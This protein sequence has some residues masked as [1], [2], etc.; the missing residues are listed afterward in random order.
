MA[1]NKVIYGNNTLIDISDTT[2][3]ESD[4]SSGAVFYKNNGVR[5]VGTAS[6][7]GFP[8]FTLTGTITPT[9]SGG[10]IES[11][12]LKYALTSDRTIGMI[13]GGALVRGAGAGVLIT[14]SLGVQ[15]S[16][17]PSSDV[18]IKGLMNSSVVTADNSSNW[19]VGIDTSGNVTLNYQCSTNRAF[20]NLV[21]SVVRFSDFY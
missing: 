18:Q 2:A 20:I 6:G 3:T 17:A 5:S 11:S 21:P 9:V 7:G 10:S 19:Y 13:W 8:E 16:P 4:V 1:I 15:V 12:D 14:M